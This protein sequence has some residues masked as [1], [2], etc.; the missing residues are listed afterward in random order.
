VVN[1][2]ERPEVPI[3]YDTYDPNVLS[4]QTSSFIASM[5]ENAEV[6][7]YR[8]TKG[9]STVHIEGKEGLDLS[10]T[11]DPTSATPISN[12]LFTFLADGIT[13]N[14]Y[15][16]NAN[17]SGSNGEF[18]VAGTISDLVDLNNAVF[19]KNALSKASFSLSFKISG[20]VGTGRLAVGP[21]I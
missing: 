1:V 15:A 9:S 20:D 17:V 7:V 21:R 4:F 13:Y 18:T 16:L 11:Y 12:L 5:N 6:F 19:D 8:D 10:F 3:D 2:K 14:A